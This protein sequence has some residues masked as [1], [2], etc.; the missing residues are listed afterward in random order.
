MR[1]T[2]LAVLAFGCT[3]FYCTV[4]GCTAFYCTGASSLVAAELL[5]PQARTAFQTNEWIDVS[6]VRSVDSGTLAAGPLQLTLAGTDGSR[7]AFEFPVDGGGPRRTE[8][9]HVHGGLLRPGKY[10]VEAA[11]DGQSAKAEID[12][13]GH[14]RRSSFKVINWGRANKPAEQLVQGEDNLGFN[15]FYGHYG[16]DENADL[17]RAGVDFMANCV[18]GGGHQMDLRLECDWSDPYVTRGGTRRVVRQA[19]AD[20]LRPNVLGVHFYDEPGLTW[21]KHPV[22]GKFGP[23]EVAAQVRAYV[24]AFGR[25]PQ[26]SHTLDPQNAEQVA[27]WKHWATWKL[28]FMDAAWKESQFGVSQVRPD[29][30][31]V[32]QSQY[33]WTAFTDGYYFN[34]VRSLPVT[35]GHGGYHDFGPG[36]F[37]PSYFLEMSRARDHAKPCW[38]LPTWYGNTTAD[39]FRLE[40]YLAFQTNVQGLMS[41]PDLEPALNPTGRQGIVESN[42]LVQRLGPIF[43]TMPV[44]KPP[45]ALLYSLSQALHSQTKNT[46]DNNYA[47]ALPHGK[48]L[49]L[50]YLAG[51]LIQQPF[52]PVLDEDVLDGTLAADH[53]AIVLTSVDYL[54]PPV[55]AALERFAADGGL[56]LL[57]ADASVAIR[58]AKRLGVAPRMP[59]QEKIDELM[60]AGKWSETGPY[61][62]TAK[63]YEGALPLGRAIQVELAKA[64]VSPVFGS[65]VP[66]I[67]A[68]RQAV[69]DV[70]YLFAVN[71]TADAQAKDAKG[72]PEKNAL[73]P[74][75]A[76]LSFARSDRPV[77]D[78]V[79][80]GRIKFANGESALRFGPGQMRVFARPAR[81]IGGVRVA[82]PTV[83]RQLA[84]D[85]APLQLDLAASV[86]DDQGGLLSGSLPLQVRVLD[87]LGGTRF[88]LFRATKL[89]Q[90]A[91]CLPLA[92]NDPAGTWRVEVTELLGP[93]TG[94]A[95]FAFTPPTLARS[96]AG[97]TPRAVSADRDRENIFRFV[98]THHAVTIV[99]GTSPFHAAA[100]ERLTQGLAPWGV[101]CRRLPL[102]EAA[103]SRTL[104]EEEARTWIGLVH[105]GTGQ[106]KPGSANPPIHAGF[107][108]QGPVILLGT[109]EDNVLI[110]FL[111]Q[112]R[113]LP[114]KPSAATF[115]GVG[116]GMIAWQRDALGPGQESV[117]LLAYDEAGLNE[118]VGSFYEAATGIE[119]LTKW[120][121][122]A[123]GTIAPATT[124][125]LVPAAKRLWEAR[126]PDRVVGFS[127]QPANT[128]VL[129][130]DGWLTKLDVATGTPLSSETLTD[131]V[132]ADRAAALASKP[133][134]AQVAAA[135]K[136]AG[137]SRLVKLTLAHGD[138]LA[139]AYW[140]GT[141]DVRT[142]DG[143]LKSRTVLPQDITALASSGNHLLVGLADGRVVALQSP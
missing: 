119:P 46:D 140:G 65:S 57:T 101:T 94:T 121:W 27:R 141:L 114:Y 125:H 47:H 37:N 64:G 34:V 59:D 6:V 1:T 87:P 20:R 2:W 97:A 138:S 13:F 135:Q 40:Q 11:V 44:T 106:I 126:L 104:T 50:A 98:R 71:A 79:R 19:L 18:M 142:A 30:L 112:E 136:H 10:A 131:A 82:T 109:P 110:K 123:S 66:T 12:V 23:H 38:Y 83:T 45:V 51:K 55:V 89:G 22:T 99:A 139:A 115:P 33:G 84:N 116:R 61:T 80:G 14:L 134:A 143:V 48:N 41:P 122:P 53:R 4:F 32:T 49:P 96:I 120:T 21:Q 35:S 56:V 15:L 42:Q 85:L 3:V 36:V 16:R 118:A 78:A 67:I 77:Y 58:G 54:D 72:Q 128:L 52:Q 127:V 103:K 8:H 69:G 60:K 63:H 111:Q 68:S 70:E 105:S 29:F 124:A 26:P 74:V 137:P 62:T 130:H 102:D 24:A 5:F 90:L 92:A 28:G 93:T 86:V 9:L 43:T 95:T 113:F 76:T 88:E 25:P 108:V 129:T 132:Y 81:P 31:S 75:A 17:L 107:A 39:Q 7:L 91:L 117:V 73:A 100:A 133:D